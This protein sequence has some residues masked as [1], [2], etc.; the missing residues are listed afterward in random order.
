MATRGDPLATG[1]SVV[2]PGS[3]IPI[4]PSG[5][6]RPLR[7]VLFSGL[8]DLPREQPTKLELVINLKTVKALDLTIRQSMLIRA[9][10]GIQ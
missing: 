4:R 1:R 6:A 3:G 8:G 7:A 9:E 2:Q 10:G 5:R